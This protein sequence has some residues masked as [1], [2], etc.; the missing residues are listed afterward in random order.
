MAHGQGKVHRALLDNMSIDEL[1][2]CAALAHG[3]LETEASG[4]IHLE[5]IANI[6]A[7]GVDYA[8]I[9]QLTHSA[10]SVDLALHIDGKP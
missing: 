2:Q 10:G 8:S 3:R 6:A 9:G 5:N 7:T 4:G 1:R